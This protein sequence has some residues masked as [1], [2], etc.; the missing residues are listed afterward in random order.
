MAGITELA[1]RYI[2]RHRLH[3]FA[4]WVARAMS[5][6][7]RG[8]K[9]ED[10][11]TG[12]SYRKMLSYGRGIHH[13]Q[14]VLAPDSLSLERH[15]LM[16]L[17]LQRHTNFFTDPVKL[18]HIAPEYCFLKL[19][20]GMKN[21]EY[22]TADLNS[23]WADIH[24]DVHDIPMEDNS[25][26]AVI[27]NH[28]LEHVDD[29]AQVMRE[30]FRVMRP[31]GWGIFQ[32]PLDINAEKTFEDPTVTDPKERERL[33]WQD[34]HVRLYGMDYPDRLAAAGFEV[35]SLNMVD[36]MDAGLV[37]KYALMPG[38]IVFFCRKPK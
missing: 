35:E 11:I 33:F 38:E 21:L 6:F 2:P 34:D 16:W 28:V 36:E 17:V 26:D 8:S 32:V 20:K 14:N 25:F 22:V 9:Y 19:F 1:L 12:I 15:R 5:P 3:I 4:H 30:F 18:L 23:P 10:P 13:R 24:M 31:G 37:E 7:M 29:D 27:C